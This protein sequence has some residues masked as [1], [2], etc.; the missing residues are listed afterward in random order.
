MEPAVKKILSALPLLI[1][2]GLAL[3]LYLQPGHHPTQLTPP[4]ANATAL[5]PGQTPA[6]EALTPTS[7]DTQKKATTLALP[8][9]FTVSYTHL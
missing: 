6:A 7:Q 3:M 2:A 5:Q 4:A 9:S 8:S 1:V